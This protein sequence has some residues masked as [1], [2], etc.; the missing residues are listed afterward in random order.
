MHLPQAAKILLAVVC[1]KFW[2]D[3]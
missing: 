1:K 2:N 3:N